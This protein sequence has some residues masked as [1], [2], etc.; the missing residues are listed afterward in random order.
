MKCETCQK[1]HDG[2]YGSGRFC[3]KSCASVF[4]T[5]FNREKINKKIS[6]K[7]KGFKFINNVKV[8]INKY[9][10]SCEIEI[11]GRSKI[12]EE[13]KKYYNYQDLFKK[14]NISDKNVKIA[15]DKCLIILKD[16]YFKNRLSSLEL[17]KKYKIQLNTLH[18]YMKKNGIDLRSNSVSGTL[19]Y[20]NNKLSPNSTLFYKNGWHTTWEN[21]Q[22][23]LRSSYEFNYAKQ[24]DE[25]KIK[26]D[27]ENVR[28]RYYDTIKQ[29]ERISI[30]DFYL[31][32]LN[33]KVEIK[34]NYTLNLQNMIDKFKEYKNKGYKTKL[35]VEG[36]EMII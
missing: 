5:K 8:K 29:K 27:V 31:P 14:L 36:K 3:S 32:D 12:C 26:Y 28:I 22:V 17:R 6:E 1:E 13:C 35:I 16:E 23:Y 20:E 7:L 33:M 25:Y 10:K 34:S 21:K 4:S 18:F 15:N 19:A 30:T 9:C 11:N 2:Q 24:L